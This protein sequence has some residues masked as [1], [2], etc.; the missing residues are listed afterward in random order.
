MLIGACFYK[1]YSPFDSAKKDDLNPLAIKAFERDANEFYKIPRSYKNDIYVFILR[2]DMLEYFGTKAPATVILSL[3]S[4]TD[5]PDCRYI[6]KK[7]SKEK[8]DSVN[9]L[10]RG[11]F[12][13]F[14][15]TLSK[16]ALV[17]R[18]YWLSSDSINSSQYV[19]AD[20][21]WYS[22]TGDRKPVEKLVWNI[23]ENGNF[24]RCAY[25]AVPFVM[26]QDTTFA[27]YVLSASG[28]YKGNKQVDSL[29]NLY[30]TN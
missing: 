17:K 20:M 5:K 6:Q 26:K 4:M 11:G 28:K 13:C 1:P 15:S 9:K 27:S 12:Y 21:G 2:S 10:T 22:V 16:E 25:W 14:D 29:L 3:G 23:A 7:V 24:C 18:N 19:D 30:R 8:L